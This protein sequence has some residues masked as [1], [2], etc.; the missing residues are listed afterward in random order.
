MRR[1]VLSHSGVTITQEKAA[2]LT[3]L[4][5]WVVRMECLS[6]TDRDEM[7]ERVTVAQHNH[8]VG[9][10]IASAACGTVPAGTGPPSQSR[11]SVPY[12]LG[13]V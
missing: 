5:G 2:E 9:L 3:N 11:H 13:R 1:A 12:G 7:L 8:A 4:V 10:H 6:E